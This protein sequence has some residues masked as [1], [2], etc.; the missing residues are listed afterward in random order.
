MRNEKGQ[1]VKGHSVLESWR[2]SIS[3]TQKGNT[4]RRGT[5]HTNE[6]KFKNSIAHIGK[7]AWNKGMFGKLAVNWQGGKTP[8]LDRIRKSTEY[9][10]WRKSVLE[11]DEYTCHNCGIKKRIGMRV[12]HKYQFSIFPEIRMSEKNGITLCKECH[13]EVHKKNKPLEKIFKNIFKENYNWI[14]GQNL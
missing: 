12:H 11:R 3:D 7:S 8:I 9:K 4:Y 10:K 13:K 5:K 14:I 2:K 1:F 6:S